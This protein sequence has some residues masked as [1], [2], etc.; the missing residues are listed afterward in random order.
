MDAY[1]FIFVGIVIFFYVFSSK[2][3]RKVINRYLV[4]TSQIIAYT[5][6]AIGTLA[7]VIMAILS[8]PT[9]TYAVA[10][11][12]DIALG[13]YSAIKNKNKYWLAAL[14]AITTIIALIIA[15]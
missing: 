10:F 13:I 14:L 12:V 7:F 1:A 11:I 8:A 6:L 15:L 2:H 3:T 5:V 9:L 4:D